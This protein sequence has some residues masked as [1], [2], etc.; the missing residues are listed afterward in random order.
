M[1]RKVLTSTSFCRFVEFATVKEAER[2][3]T[4]FDHFNIG[5]GE[6]L[7][8]RIKSNSQTRG[9]ASDADVIQKIASGQMSA[10]SIG[11]SHDD[12]S[13][14]QGRSAP[15][16]SQGDGA[17]QLRRSK[18]IG[19]VATRKPWEAKD[20]IET[21]SNQP[22]SQSSQSPQD[23]GRVQQQSRSPFA[24]LRSSM[25]TP[26][27]P[28]TEPY[29]SL[30]SPTP[31]N[32]VATPTSPY[33]VASNS[34][35][36]VTKLC[37]HCGKV[38]T[39]RCLAC[40]APYCSK[41][42]QQADWPEHSKECGTSK[43]HEDSAPAQPSGTGAKSSEQTIVVDPTMLATS[44]DFDISLGH[45]ESPVSSPL[46]E[47]PPSRPSSDQTSPGQQGLGPQCN[48]IYSGDPTELISILNLPNVYQVRYISSKQVRCAFFLAEVLCK[49][50]STITGT[51]KAADAKG[52]LT[53]FYP[54]CLH[55]KAKVVVRLNGEV[56]R[57]EVQAI[58]GNSISAELMD[59]GQYVEVSINDVYMMPNEIRL[60]PALVQKYALYGVKP[61]QCKHPEETQAFL[62]SHV[63][64][65]VLTVKVMG[66][67]SFGQLALL[68][69]PMGV[70]I[71]D[72]LCTSE[73]FAAMDL[74]SRQHSNSHRTTWNKELQVHKPP[75]SEPF[76]IIP[77]V[78]Y[79][80]T[81]IWAQV[82]HEHLEILA[83]LIRD[84][85]LHYSQSSSAGFVPSRGELCAAVSHKDNCWYR[86]EVMSVDHVSQ[87]CGVRFIDYGDKENVSL[88]KIRHLDDV[89][90]TLPRQSLHF[91]LANVESA[92]ESRLWTDNVIDAINA[93]LTDRAVKVEV[94]A[95]NE[96]FHY[97]VKMYDPDDPVNALNDSLVASGAAK[98]VPLPY[99]VTVPAPTLPVAGFGRA[100][101]ILKIARRSQP[102]AQPVTATVTTP[103]LSLPKGHGQGVGY[104][105]SVPS[106]HSILPSSPQGQP[107][108]PQLPKRPDGVGVTSGEEQRSLDYQRKSPGGITSWSPVTAAPQNAQDQA[109]SQMKA[110]Q[111]SLSEAPVSVLHTPPVPPTQEFTDLNIAGQK[112][113]A[114]TPPQPVIPPIG[115]NFAAVVTHVESVELFYIQVAKQDTLA[116]LTEMSTRAAQES[117]LDSASV[118]TYCMAFSDGVYYRGKVVEAISAKEV[119]V[120]F[121]DFGN[122][123]T[124]FADRLR[125]C[126]PQSA[127][128]PAMAI[129]CALAGA[130][131]L[132]KGAN[133]FF[134]ELVM[135][136]NVMAVVRGVGTNNIT[137]VMLS[138]N[139][140]RKISSLL[141]QQGFVS[142]SGEHK[143]PP[144]QSEVPPTSPQFAVDQLPKCS[145]S[146]GTQ[147]MVAHADSPSSLWLQLG[148]QKTLDALNSLQQMLQSPPGAQPLSSL[149]PLHS[150][151][152]AKF[153]ED[154]C[155][156]RA[157]VL[158]HQAN[159]QIRV[160]FIDYGN[161]SFVALSDTRPFVKELLTIAPQAIECSLT[162]I[163]PVGGGTWSNDAVSLLLRHTQGA[164]LTVNSV[165]Q[166]G[167]S[168]Y[169]VCLV[170]SQ[171]KSLS[172]DL[173]AE[174]LAVKAGQLPSSPH[175]PAS[176]KQPVQS[177]GLQH[178]RLMQQNSE[179]FQQ[180]SSSGPALFP[181]QEK[182]PTSTAPNRQQTSP[183]SRPR[184]NPP[185]P[186]IHFTP[187]KPKVTYQQLAPPQS[188]FKALVMCVNSPSSIW[189]QVLDST[190]QEALIALY[191]KL[192]S[193]AD[194]CPPS[195]VEWKPSDCCAVLSSDDDTWYRA[196]V[197][198]ATTPSTVTVRL[199]DFGLE[200]V[201]SVAN[202]R[203]LTDEFV[204][205]P[206]QALHAKLADT[207][208]A[209][210]SRTWSQPAIHCLQDLILEKQVS[211]EVVSHEEDKLVVEMCDSSPS[212]VS[213]SQRLKESAHAKSTMPPKLPPA[214]PVCSTK[215]PASMVPTQ[216][217]RQSAKAPCPTTSPQRQRVRTCDCNWVMV[218]AVGETFSAMV[219]HVA[220]VG[221]VWIQVANKENVSSL[222][223]LMDQVNQHALSP[224]AQPFTSPPE[225]GELC[226]AQFSED[227]MWYRAT[228][229]DVSPAATTVQF[230]DFGNVDTLS[231]SCIC[232]IPS[233]FL[234]LPFQ[235]V[236]GSLVGLPEHECSSPSVQLTARF[237]QLV[238]GKC[239]TCEVISGEPLCIN[240]M[241]ASDESGVTVRD[242]LVRMELLPFMEDSSIPKVEVAE[243]HLSEQPTIIIAYDRGPSDF[244]IQ[245]VSQGAVQNFSQMMTQLSK[246]CS[247]SPQGAQE[248]LLGQIVCAKFYEDQSW[249]RSRVIGFVD[250]N[251]VHVQFIDFGNTDIVSVGSLIPIHSDFTHIP[252]QAVHCCLKGF[253]GKQQPS[254]D[255]IDKFQQLT[256]NKALIAEVCGVVCDEN[257]SKRCV[258]ELAD[259][260]SRD[261][262]ISCQL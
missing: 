25:N 31:V 158:E 238:D 201:T 172:D 205:L 222:M 207:V 116:T 171:G 41:E 95:Y 29:T 54:S 255:V 62:E 59:F 159:T 72:V 49:E 98:H 7:K 8:V 168:K 152:V 138:L 30:Q 99:G 119:V 248:A 239:L 169:V 139:D 84:M 258:V 236:C 70:C 137:D 261:V 13:V 245:A 197:L 200:Q 39:K 145:L 178:T 156:Y 136:Q 63:K 24:S 77:T 129:T 262:K 203:L 122:S 126:D 191:N 133:E 166:E 231:P 192:A 19:S 106:P 12:Q 235:A 1:Y 256:G 234:S 196:E 82:N 180:S 254:N 71:N 240:L 225:R 105:R 186:P 163:E 18:S 34:E 167:G 219:S 58:K 75:V 177:P 147:V 61:M 66:R 6:Y 36:K 37:T 160:R 2:A 117:P 143:P 204:Q 247:R 4:E 223:E 144:Q 252:A 149:P 76:Q 215:S 15:W 153:S 11:H 42:C 123:E 104:S 96:P 188:R 92:H 154:G 208:P 193:C 86:A 184:N 148:A 232:H 9:P 51:L 118:G 253:E 213:V 79:N 164:M 21:D 35:Q 211:I 57:A 241:D 87:M 218:P 198:A 194:S 26:S 85:T 134:T 64:D 113:A 14:V 174:G 80:P 146:E 224:M 251:N 237:R 246:Y 115:Q 209:D 16:M 91:Q 22:H 161:S 244:Y 46:H 173:L 38:S 189:F 56:S 195:S 121:I 202:M 83:R 111:N 32:G 150:L 199:V 132:R 185:T 187:T 93:K 259:A 179:S 131:R 103:P 242:S 40:K 94:L 20:R 45:L 89:F 125:R 17:S 243:I 216:A 155:W 102:G 10:G 33:S 124:M 165:K 47:R 227:Q 81:H 220:S 101:T 127:L 140:G 212:K 110:S 151:C 206:A 28:E 176:I 128:V 69:D 88:S 108:S 130:P 53:L 55:E 182:L 141:L 257:G 214:S 183:L 73:F 135:D 27:R 78:V 44:S 23:V 190:S 217:L 109:S 97:F 67:N 249:Y 170:D 90:W 230:V 162:G 175:S 181:P 120:Q 260:S 107:H 48:G 100:A 221:K 5:C 210:G 157:L 50:K 233:E 228:V 229:L 250:S 74:L 43:A 226:L 60:L 112:S 142:S 52:A 114:P 65:K 3:L 68:Y